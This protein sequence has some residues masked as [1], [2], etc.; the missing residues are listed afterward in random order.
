MVL[1][2]IPNN[3]TFRWRHNAEL[4]IQYSGEENNH[5]F[6]KCVIL[7]TGMYYHLYSDGRQW[8]QLRTQN[9]HREGKQSEQ[10]KRAQQAKWAQQANKASIA[11]QTKQAK[12]MQQTQAT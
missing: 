2:S 7:S 9:K 5:V 11:K 8:S 3:N 4:N 10:A 6:Q 12:Q 1:Y